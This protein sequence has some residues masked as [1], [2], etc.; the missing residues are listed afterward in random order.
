MQEDSST[1]MGLTC[2]GKGRQ[3]ATYDITGE[4]LDLKE[5]KAAR[6][7]EMSF[8]KKIPVFKV[9]KVHERHAGTGPGRLRSEQDGL[10]LRKAM[11]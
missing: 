3:S 2:K 9:K 7:E 1:V 10:V 5:V 8:V 11:A 6:A 4:P